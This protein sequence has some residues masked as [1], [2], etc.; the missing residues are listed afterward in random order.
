MVGPEWKS[1]AIRA[2]QVAA[3]PIDK[4]RKLA[5]ATG[6]GLGIGAAL[7]A[8]LIMAARKRIEKEAVA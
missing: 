5:D 3:M 4:V 1:W 8:S 7:C 6:S 2:T